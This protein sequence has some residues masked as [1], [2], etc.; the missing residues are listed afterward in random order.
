VEP[1][2]RSPVGSP[3]GSPRAPGGRPARGL[4]CAL[5]ALALA[6]AAA[7]AEREPAGRLTQA[8]AHHRHGSCEPLPPNSPGGDG[9]H[10]RQDGARIT[11]S[12]ARHPFEVGHYGLWL[13]GGELFAR[14]R[15]VGRA[16]RLW[17]P[18]PLAPRC[19][20]D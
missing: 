8:R 20:A 16:D 5:A 4:A 18:L 7:A 2:R 11:Q 10:R 14:V 15:G 17:V 1:H 9:V 3:R 6:G 12:S 19:P 13:F